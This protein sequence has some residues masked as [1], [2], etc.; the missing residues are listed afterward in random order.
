MSPRGPAMNASDDGDLVSAAHPTRCSGCGRTFYST[1]TRRGMRCRTA[2]AADNG[3]APTTHR[4]KTAP[5]IVI[6]TYPERYP[7]TCRP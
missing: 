4:P 7:T 2:A 6:R 1:G 3:T 5:R